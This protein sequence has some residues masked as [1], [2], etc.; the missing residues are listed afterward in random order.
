MKQESR[1]SKSLVLWYRKNARDLPWRNTK[2]PYAIWLSEIILQQTTVQQGTPYYNKFIER[3]PNIQS[4]ALADI[5]EVLKLWQGL[6]YYSRARNLH[7]AAKHIYGELDSVFPISYEKII[8]LKGVGKYTAAAIA[9]FCFNEARVVVDGNVKRVISRMYGIEEPIDNALLEK[10]ITELAH[11]LMIHQAPMEF[12][13]A[14]M[15]IGA[16][17]CKKSKPSC[18]VC[19]F[20]SF[21]VA[22][23]KNIQSEIP[24]KSKRIKKRDRFFYYALCLDPENNILIRHRQTNDIWKG[25][26]ELPLVERDMALKNFPALGRFGIRQSARKKEYSRVFKHQLSH[27]T[28]YAQFSVFYLDTVIPKELKEEYQIIK[29]EQLENYPVPRLIDLYLSDLSITLF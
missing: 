27:Q 23:A 25:L 10:R 5:D 26:Y 29:Y 7:E 6:G 19:P 4:L 28:I 12:N 17:V 15:E 2:D 21:C 13:Q 24:I 16:L 3:F 11:N 18:D 20:S 9:S 14:I 8:K 22:K 1:L